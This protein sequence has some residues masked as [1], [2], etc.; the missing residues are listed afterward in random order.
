MPGAHALTP[1]APTSC[2]RMRS[3]AIGRIL[4]EQCHVHGST[5]VDNDYRHTGVD[6]ES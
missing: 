2:A 1:A 6:F 5:A 3:L 4:F